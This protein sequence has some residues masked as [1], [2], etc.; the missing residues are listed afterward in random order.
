MSVESAKEFMTKLNR[1]LVFRNHVAAAKDDAAR[2]KLTQDEGFDFTA[3]EIR[4]VI[5]E[6]TQASGE[7]LSCQFGG[8]LS[9]LNPFKEISQHCL[10]LCFTV[11]GR[12]REALVVDKQ[13]T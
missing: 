9:F 13:Q 12:L 6:L 3:A 7:G 4:Q 1:D 10:N 2:D 8:G 11:L 5:A